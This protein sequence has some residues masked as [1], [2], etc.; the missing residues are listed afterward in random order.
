MIV[1]HSDMK[2]IHLLI[3]SMVV[4]LLTGCST[5]ELDFRKD[6]PEE[7]L[8]I[9]IESY[10]EGD[11]IYRSSDSLLVQNWRFRQTY[12]F[13]ENNRCEYLFSSPVDAHSM[14]KGYWDYDKEKMILRIYSLDKALLHDLKVVS[15]SDDLLL[16][17]LN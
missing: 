3:I 13:M 10:E 17:D 7:F 1:S 12:H 2:R 9:W 8:N 4:L 16:L 15:I 11:G 5:D 14:V 6:Y